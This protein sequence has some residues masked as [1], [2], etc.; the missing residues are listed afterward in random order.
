[1]AARTCRKS[2]LQHPKTESA[3]R[4]HEYFSSSIFS[5]EPIG[6]FGNAKRNFFHGPGYNY[7]DMTFYKDFPL[8]SKRP[9]TSNSA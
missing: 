7:G 9:G 1:M 4:N 2:Q 5:A 8:A 6:T 3:Q